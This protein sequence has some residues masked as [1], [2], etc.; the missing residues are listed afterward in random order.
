MN[1]SILAVAI[2]ALAAPALAQ[3]ATAD[4]NVSKMD[5]SPSWNL[6]ESDKIFLITSQADTMKPMTFRVGTIDQLQTVQAGAGSGRGSGT[7]F[8][9]YDTDVFADFALTSWL[10]VGL[11]MNY[12]SLGDPATVNLPAPTG[13]VKVQYLRQETA[14]V[15]AAVAVN[16]K[17]IGFSRPMGTNPNDGELEAQFMFDK[18]IGKVMLS[19]NGVFGKSFSAPDSDTELKL[20]AGYSVFRNLVVGVDSITRYDTSFDGG[21]HDGTRYWEFTGGAMT[22]LKVADFGVSALAGVVAPMHVPLGN[23]GIG[24]TVMIQLTYT[25]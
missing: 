2:T 10:Q 3:E 11:T 23:P 9:G 5:P 24:P 25:K 15:N 17:K 6:S 12:G 7:G 22:T 21:P 19:A 4:I 8:T 14:G 18:R 16:A 20:A 13:Y 1:R